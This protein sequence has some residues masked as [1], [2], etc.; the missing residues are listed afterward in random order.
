M[1]LGI[2]YTTELDDYNTFTFAFDANKLLVP[3]PPEITDP[4]YNA[5]ST[6]FTGGIN[7]DKSVVE[8]IFT[9]FGDA[10]GDLRRSC[11]KSPSRQ[12]GILVQPTVRA[13][14]RV[15]S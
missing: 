7:S 3:T 8:G 14:C 6:L 13:P 11:R 12:G 10:P 4:Y 15:L 1:K 5:D 2:A 9:S